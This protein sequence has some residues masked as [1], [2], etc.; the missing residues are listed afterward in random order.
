[1]KGSGTPGRATIELRGHTVPAPAVP[2]V[3]DLERRRPARRPIERV[4]AR[5]DRVAMWALLMGLILILVAIGT[6]DA[7]AVISLTPF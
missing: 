2:R 7:P 6:A 1:M 4:G 3:V 5:P